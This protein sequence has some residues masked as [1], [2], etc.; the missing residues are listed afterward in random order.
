MRKVQNICIL[1]TTTRLLVHICGKMHVEHLRHKM[2]R[3]FKEISVL[4]VSHGHWTCC[5]LVFDHKQ[6][7]VAQSWNAV[8]SLCAW[9]LTS[10]RCPWLCAQTPWISSASLSV[11]LFVKTVGCQDLLQL[12]C[13]VLFP[14][15]YPSFVGCIPWCMYSTCL[16]ERNTFSW[17]ALVTRT[18]T[19]PGE[20][21]VVHCDTT[22]WFLCV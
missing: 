7:A 13:S 12:K 6:M 21:V 15:K 3:K 11:I 14:S 16:S 18:N 1:R 9:F 10:C 22:N 17:S 2:Q 5:F 19:W 20:K 4:K 8:C